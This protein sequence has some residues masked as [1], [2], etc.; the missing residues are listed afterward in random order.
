MISHFSKQHWI[1]IGAGL[2]ILTACAQPT[3]IPG[4][5]DTAVAATVA[6]GG[7][8]IAQQFADQR[9][10]LTVNAPTLTATSSPTS[11]PTQTLLPSIT[12]TSVGT[13]TRT[14][15]P[16]TPTR[17][18]PPPPTAT[19]TPAPVVAGTYGQGSAC[20]NVPALGDYYDPV[21]GRTV[22][23]NASGWQLCI[24][25]V[26]VQEAGAML[27]NAT[28]TL[29]QINGPYYNVNGPSQARLP[30]WNGSSHA[31]Y[32]TDNLGRRY[33]FTDLSGAAR[34][35]GN[36]G[37]YGSISGVFIFP[38]P[39]RGATQLAYHDDDR[40]NLITLQLTSVTP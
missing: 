13:A 5:L 14:P 31:I 17:T 26:V 37:P 23:Y 40:H 18:L 28:W 8:H 1:V 29:G 35:G 12:P 34:E 30:P 20:A 24:T 33:D 4:A 16:P 36:S 25:S 15:R 32:L 27:L 39:L 2:L 9:H 38:A 10:A 7:T 19:F 22:T 3:P 21:M 11:T 6:V